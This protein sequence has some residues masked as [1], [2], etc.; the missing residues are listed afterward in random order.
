MTEE[1]R[2]SKSPGPFNGRRY[3]QGFRHAIEDHEEGD[4]ISQMEAHAS[5]MSG[6]TWYSIGYNSAINGIKEG[7][8][9]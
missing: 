9:I 8:A 7:Q 1:E 6:R 3:S 4:T 2:M 5:N